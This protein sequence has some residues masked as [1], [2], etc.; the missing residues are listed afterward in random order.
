MAAAYSPARWSV[1]R[2]R[3]SVSALPPF[4]WMGVRSTCATITEPVMVPGPCGWAL[5]A[6]RSAVALWL[7]CL[8]ARSASECY[9]QT[10]A[11]AVRLPSHAHLRA[12]L[13]PWPGMAAQRDAAPARNGS[14]E[15]PAAGRDNG[16]EWCSA[17]GARVGMGTRQCYSVTCAWRLARRRIGRRAGG[18][19]AA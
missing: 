19:T 16:D 15:F 14:A 4:R 17:Y 13:F 3:A 1:G 2:R 7:H 12:T 6:R 18:P 5:W 8:W 10:L 11:N 9:T